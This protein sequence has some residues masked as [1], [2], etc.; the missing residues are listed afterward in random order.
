MKLTANS[1]FGL[2]YL[3]WYLVISFISADLF[4][5]KGMFNEWGSFVR[6]MFL[7]GLFVVTIIGI[8]AAA[9]F[10]EVIEFHKG[11]R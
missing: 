2:N 4:W 5:V 3:F 7:F 6:V 8:A 1:V 10:E 9:N 11:K